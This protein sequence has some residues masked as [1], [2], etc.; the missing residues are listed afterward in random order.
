MEDAQETDREQN[1]CIDTGAQLWR[2]AV[3]QSYI[4]SL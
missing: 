2:K 1:L 3:F 4:L